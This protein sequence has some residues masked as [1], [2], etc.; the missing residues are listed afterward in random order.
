[1]SQ[2]IALDTE[3]PDFSLNDFSG[4]PVRLSQHRSQHH[5]ILVFNRGFL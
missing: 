2:K 5:V 1:M 4:Q 3:A